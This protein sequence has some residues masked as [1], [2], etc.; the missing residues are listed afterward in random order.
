MSSSR[1]LLLANAFYEQQFEIQYLR[2]K[3]N[4]FQCSAKQ[5][6]GQHFE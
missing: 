1:Q 6:W 3:G 4:Q 5:H 2:A